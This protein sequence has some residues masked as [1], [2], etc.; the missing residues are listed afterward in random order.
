MNT[1]TAFMVAIGLPTIIGAVVAI[2]RFKASR[3]LQSTVDFLVV[4]LI[5]SVLLWLYQPG[6]AGLY[7]ITPG[8]AVEKMRGLGRISA[9]FAALAIL[10]SIFSLEIDY[11]RYPS[12][13]DGPDRRSVARKWR[14]MLAA[15]AGLWGLHTFAALNQGRLPTLW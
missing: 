11:S 12:M 3:T 2:L 4:V 7:G 15:T 13:A 10:W 8:N 6:L 14:A 1:L 9:L 5:A